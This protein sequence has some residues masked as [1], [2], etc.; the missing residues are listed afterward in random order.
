MK[1]QIREREEKLGRD[2]KRE[3]TKEVLDWVT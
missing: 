3:R 1:K 2:K